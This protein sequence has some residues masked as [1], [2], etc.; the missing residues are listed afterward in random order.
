ME[1]CH[2]Q[3]RNAGILSNSSDHHAVTP[4]GLGGMRQTWAGEPLSL[5][6]SWL[7]C[8]SS[9][10]LDFY[11]SLLDCRKFEGDR[12]GKTW[13]KKSR[14]L[15]LSPRMGGFLGRGMV[16]SA[17]LGALCWEDGG[18]NPH[19]GLPVSKQPGSWW[20]LAEKIH[21]CVS[22]SPDSSV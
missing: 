18:G 5:P 10:C 1:N 2:L 3:C 15:T 21:Q 12:S 22:L 20:E 11:A 13:S 16:Q 9:L 8:E 19:L 14:E 7:P 17:L 4:Y 6:L